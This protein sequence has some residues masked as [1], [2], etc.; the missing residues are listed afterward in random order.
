MTQEKI[1]EV[2][3]LH[4][5][6]LYDDPCGIQANL[7]GANLQGA[8]FQEA[9]FRGADFREANLR[10]ADFQGANLFCSCLPLWRGGLKIKMDRLQ[11]GQLAYHFCS[12]IIADKEVE[13]L[14]KCLYPLA[15]EFAKSRVDLRN[16]LY[17]EEADND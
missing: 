11:M 8:D 6:W 4:K 16:K 14:Q 15:N 17:S 5:L 9:D 2:L 12:M 3:R 7:R 10:G 1:N 13:R